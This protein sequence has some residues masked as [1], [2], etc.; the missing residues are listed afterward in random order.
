MKVQSRFDSKKIGELVCDG[1]YNDSG[2]I[3]NG[4]ALMSITLIHGIG[5][6]LRGSKKQYTITELC[7]EE[8]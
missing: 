4:S 2:M 7:G 3:C 1:A 5:R 8:E 6:G